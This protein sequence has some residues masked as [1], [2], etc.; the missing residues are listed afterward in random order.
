MP[1]KASSDL[2]G[3]PVEDYDRAIS[4]AGKWLTSQQRPDGSSGDG[5]TIWAYYTQPMAFR[6][7]GQP[8]AAMRCLSFTRKEF[9]HGDGVPQVKREGVEGITYAPAWMVV[10]SHMWDRF[11]VSY[12]T[13]E[14]ILRFQDPETGGFYSSEDEAKRKVGLLEYEATLVSGL[15][16]VSTGR[17]SQAEKVARFLQRTHES[18]P[19][20]DERYYFMWDKKKG[21]VTDSFDK[22]LTMFYVVEK[23]EQRQ[24]YFLFGLAI[25]FLARLYMATGTRKYLDLAEEYFDY[26]DSCAGTYSTCL[27]HKLCWAN[28]ILYQATGKRR[29]LI[30]AKRVGD[31]LI[32]AQRSDGRY[33]YKEVVPKFEDQNQTANLDIVSQFTTWLGQARSF[34][35]NP[36]GK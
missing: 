27:A 3:L 10:N 20:L 23:K 29:Y 30:G 17:I 28:A 34:F 19:E 2:P 11:E 36:V 35:P 21:L 24:G 7:V 13:V 9:I 6:A 26:A 32:G 15:A 31:Y 1:T 25:A 4:R 5:Q 33:H 16:L 14:W 8:R 18:Q 12:P 22:S